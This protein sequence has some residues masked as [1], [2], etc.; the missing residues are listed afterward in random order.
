MSVLQEIC[1]NKKVHVE[2]QK[3]RISIDDL[4]ARALD[5]S[6][7][8]GFIKALQAS[9]SPAIIAEV[10]KASPSKGVIREDFN[11]PDIAKIYEENGA[12]CLSVLTDEPYFQGHDSYLEGV[13]QVVSLPVLRKDFMVDPYQIYESRALGTDCILIIM[14]ALEDD[15]ALY[16]HDLSIELGMDVLVEVHDEAEL[17]RAARLNPEMIGVNN[18]SLK[19]LNV[20]VMTSFEL[21]SRMPE[22]TVKIAESGLSGYQVLKDLEDAGYNGFLVG[23]SLMREHDIGRALKTLRNRA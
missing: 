21:I 23:E 15:M 6:P 10:K 9:E 22:N 11:A 13:R 17:I 2:A 20:D 8:R 12:A 7:P 3:S 18:R 19:T 16:M 5:A 1:E 4:K 14:A